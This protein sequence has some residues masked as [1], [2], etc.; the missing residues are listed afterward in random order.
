MPNQEELEKMKI[1]TTEMKNVEILSTGKWNEIDVT[2]SDLDEM[3]SNFNDKVLEPYL[4]LDHDDNFTD[5]VKR[6]LS[7]VSL[8]LVSQ[9][10]KVGNKLIAD[11]IQVPKKVAE[12]IDSGMLKKRSVEFFRKGFKVN[13]KVYKNVLKAVSFFG[14][15]IPAVNNLSND[16]DI[17]LKSKD[18]AIALFNNDVKAEKIKFNMEKITMDKIEIPREEYNDLIAFR[19]A[20]ESTLVKLEAEN[21]EL[22]KITAE[23]TEKVDSLTNE[24]K[25]LT[26]FKNDAIE[27]KKVALKKEATQFVEKAI[28]DGKKLPKQKDYLISEYMEKA[29]KSEEALKLFKEDIEISG[30]CIELGEHK[31]TSETNA[32]LDFNKATNDEINEVIEQRMKMKNE[33]YEDAAKAL[34]VPGFEE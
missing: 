5:N 31:F 7:V 11:F 3:I 28:E 19:K 25:D 32:R 20:N 18:N 1:E 8:G 24:N 29:N 6:A 21:K 10:K 4:N 9:L 16:F 2:D 26:K 22:E 30:K 27:Y 12:L 17:L 34:K 13:G 23:L 14:A 33:S 15:D